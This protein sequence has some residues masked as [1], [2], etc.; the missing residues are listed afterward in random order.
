METAAP[1]SVFEVLPLV[2]HLRPLTTKSRP[3]RATD[4]TLITE[5]KSAQDA[6]PSVDPQ[7]ARPGARGDADAPRRPRGVPGRCSRRRSPT[8]ATAREIIAGVDATS[9]TSATCWPRRDVRRAASRL[10]VRLRLPRRVFAPSSRRR[11]AG[12][13]VG[14]PPRRVRRED[15]HADARRRDRRGAFALLAQAERAISTIA[16]RRR[17]RR[18]RRSSRGSHGVTRPA[19]A[20]KRE[21]FD[22]VARHHPHRG[23]AAA[24]RRRRAAAD[25]ATSTSPV[26]PRATTRT[27]SCASPR[28]RCVVG[29]QSLAE[30]DRRLASAAG[31]IRRYDDAAVARRQ[32]HALERR[33]ALLGEDFR[34][35]PE[36]ALTAAQ[37]DE[38]DNALTASRNG[39]LFRYLT[40]PP[41]SGNASRSTSRSTLALRRRPR[42]R[43]DARV[44][45]DGDNSPARSAR[46]SQR[47]RPC[48]C[49]SSRR[50]LARPRLPADGPSSTRSAA[51]HRA[52][53]RAV[54]RARRSAGCCS[55]SGPRPFPRQTRHRH[56]LPPRPART[57]RRRRRCCW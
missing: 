48:S 44:G 9:P 29:A 50:P 21:Q 49:R 10:G 35:V 56:R 3:L 52:F 1:F 39:A 51:L 54:R 45:A 14:R 43:E 26:H 57:A 42:A 23:R 16:H 12:D 47:S 28:M 4:L 22:A 55:T 33:Q 13:A 36:F 37:G 15:R 46:P 6:Q 40:E 32:V 8:C 24:R 34:I 2:R 31:P 11:P 19:F 25:H 30:L 5:A 7:R 18:R 41:R 27:R 17:C 38:I 20:A 53:R